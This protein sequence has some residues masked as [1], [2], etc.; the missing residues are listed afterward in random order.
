MILR[1]RG[2]F[3]V[4][5]LEETEM[6]TRVLLAERQQLMREGLASLLAR[7]TSLDVVAQTGDGSSAVEATEALRPHV[8]V[9]D[10]QIPG[11]NGV[12]AT[13]RIHARQPEVKILCMLEREL[14]WMMKAAL[15]AGAAGLLLKDS[16]FEEL[17]RAISSVL[18]DKLYLSP[19]LTAA[20]VQGCRATAQ[21][22]CAFS[23]LTPKEREIVQLLAEGHSTKQAAARLEISFKTVATHRERVMAKLHIRSIADLTRYAI[24]EGL[25]R[26]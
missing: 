24:R 12:D 21:S 20:A 23:V 26:L 17:T 2:R 11:L 15:D 1:K 3:P 22:D 10:L 4:D 5:A 18:R 25:A 19:A 13:R 8:V 16:S 9:I 6:H 7:E 14:P